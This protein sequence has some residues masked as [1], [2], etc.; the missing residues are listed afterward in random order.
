MRVAQRRGIENTAFKAR[1][2]EALKKVSKSNLAQ[3]VSLIDKA[4]ARH[5]LHGNKAARLK[6]RLVKKFGNPV[7][8]KK[9]IKKATKLKKR[10]KH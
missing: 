1:L 4:A 5:I 9:I 3:T 8:K 2:R 7:P 6:S 10:S